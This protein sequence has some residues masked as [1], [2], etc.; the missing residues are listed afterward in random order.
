MKSVIKQCKLC[1]NDYS[2]KDRKRSKYCSN[3]CGKTISLEHKEKISEA[4]KRYLQ[5]NKDKHPWRMSDKFKS[6]PCEKVKE[7]LTNNGI[8]FVE[9]WVPLDGRNY[10]IDIAFPDKKIGIEINGNQHYDRNGKL[11]P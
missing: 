10:S 6:I 9:E 2:T 4:R 11:K 1:G 5:E 8:K 7:F 3:K